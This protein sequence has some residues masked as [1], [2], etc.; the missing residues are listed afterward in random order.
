MIGDHPG[1]VRRAYL[2]EVAESAINTI[3]NPTTATLPEA[4]PSATRKSASIVK[5]DPHAFT[6]GRIVTV[7]LAGDARF[8]DA[9]NHATPP[10]AIALYNY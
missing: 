4:A 9:F 2:G 5:D 7:E 10:C 8:R 6:A 3:D 1:R